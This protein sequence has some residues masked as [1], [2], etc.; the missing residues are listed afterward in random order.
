MKVSL[1]YREGTSSKFWEIEVVGKTHRVRFGRIGTQGQVKEKSFASEAEALRAAEKI[2]AEKRRDGYLDARAEDAAPAEKSDAG[3]P[4]AKSRKAETP[5]ESKPTTQSTGAAGFPRGGLFVKASDGVTANAIVTKLRE[6][7]KLSK[8]DPKTAEGWTSKGVVGIA[9]HPANGGHFAVVDSADGAQG[10]GAGGWSRAALMANHLGT[11]VLWFRV[12]SPDLAVGVKFQR[13]SDGFRVVVG[14]EKRVA[15]WL[16]ASGVSA[17]DAKRPSDAGKGATLVAI[18]YDEATYKKGPDEALATELFAAHGEL[19]KGDA[20]AA[21][22]RID[23]LAPEARTLALGLLRAAESPLAFEGLRGAARELT[24]RPMTPR[25]QPKELSLD[26]EV[27]RVGAWSAAFEGDTKLFTAAVARLDEIE[28]EAERRSQWAGVTG[29]WNLAAALQA[30]NKHEGAYACFARLLLRGDE[31]HWGIVNS[32]LL[33]LL[34]S[35]KGKLVLEGEAAEVVTRAEKRLRDLGEEAQDAILYN[36]GCVYARAGDATRALDRLKRCRTLR[37][38]NANPEKDS[39]LETLWKNPAFVAL[40][41]P[42]KKPQN[43]AVVTVEELEL[44]AAATEL[45]QK[46]KLANVGDILRASASILSPAVR[47]EVS[48]AL[49]DRFG[50]K[51]G[52]GAEQG[53]ADDDDD[54]NDYTPP[55]KRAV[56]R[57]A[58]KLEDGG[59]DKKADKLVSRIGGLPNAPSNGAPWPETSRRP[60]EFVLQL[61]G[62][63]AG[64]ELDLGDVSVIQV[65]A[66]MAGDYYEENTV[67]MFREPCPAVL[68]PPAGVDVKPVRLMSFTAGADDRALIDVGDPED[69]DELAKA[70]I[71]ADD[72]EAAHSHAWCD[73]VRGVPVGANIDPKVLDSRGKPMD[74]LLT[75]TSFDDWFLWTLWVSRDFTEGAMQI[76]RG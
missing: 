60:M 11:D 50:L 34:M 13:G 15:R 71:S 55:K 76:V 20:R 69:E 61:V 47:A 57:H 41:A 9:V 25:A 52:G 43:P 6:D 46:K 67:V 8:T 32:A 16:A 4:K 37:K 23:A 51:W 33:M 40:V 42:K 48:K 10:I 35:R 31:P 64:G 14:D 72:H 70:G 44:S 21:M 12:Y 73:K 74:L 2:A 56:P 29:L 66:D 59:K 24:S 75:L 19:D 38:Q 5:L 63:K 62:K 53:A 27:L 22:K 1:E 36:L 26:E 39:D 17:D 45:L 7:G 54:A 30:S 58:I 49:D 3:E 18:Q 65:F 28:S 68:E